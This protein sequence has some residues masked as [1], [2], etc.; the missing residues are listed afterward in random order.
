MGLFHKVPI[1][2]LVSSLKF[3]LQGQS[4]FCLGR[5][6]DLSYNTKHSQ[7][8]RGK[9]KYVWPKQNCAFKRFRWASRIHLKKKRR[10]FNVTPWW[11]GEVGW[12]G[13]VAG[14]CSR[15][16]KYAIFLRVLWPARMPDNDWQLARWQA[17]QTTGRNMGVYSKQPSAYT[18][19]R[20]K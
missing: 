19:R 1:W 2:K 9:R 5:L 11:C 14:R 15:R 7:N 12:T 17:Q 18:E 10:S 16:G 4:S 6:R 8:L 3:L 13:I 20:K